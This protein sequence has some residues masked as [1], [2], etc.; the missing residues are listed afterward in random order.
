MAGQFDRHPFLL[1]P[2]AVASALKTDVDKGL[3]SAQVAQLQQ[4]YPRNELDVGGAIPWYT[5][6]IKQLFNAMILVSLNT[7]EPPPLHTP[8]KKRKRKEKK[9]KEKKRKRK[10][11]RKK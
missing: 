5:I 2:S 10:R 11:K 3:N 7:T 8:K 6:F 1:T 9:R 4:E